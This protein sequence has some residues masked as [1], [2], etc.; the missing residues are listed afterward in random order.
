MLELLHV[1]RALKHHVL[2][3]VRE[4]GAAFRLDPESDAVVDRHGDGRRGVT[5][6]DDDLQSIRQPVINDRYIDG[7]GK[8]VGRENDTKDD[9]PYAH[10]GNA[11]R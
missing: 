8:G 11:T 9:D 7:L 5:L 2:E 3:Q 4:A 1:G 6:A 10:G